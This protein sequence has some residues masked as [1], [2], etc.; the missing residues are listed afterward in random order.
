MQQVRARVIRVREIEG[1]L[2]ASR[3]EVVGGRIDGCERL[4]LTLVGEEEEQLIFDNW[5]AHRAAELLI[6]E[7]KHFVR[8]RVSGVEIA[9]AEVSEQG[10][11]ERV[12]ARFG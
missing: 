10:A 3:V 6:G 11:V 9:V 8:H 1:N 7:R 12:G 5:T 4:A 2:L